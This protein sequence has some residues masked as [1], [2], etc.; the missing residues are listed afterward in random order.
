MLKKS[1]VIAATALFFATPALSQ[2]TGAERSMIE[3]IDGRQEYAL[4]VLE[5]TVNINSGSMNIKGVQDVGQ[6]FMDEFR[7]LGMDVEWIDGSAFNRAGHVIARSGSKGPH[8]LM[9]GHLDTVFEP[10]SPFQSFTRLSDTEASGPG[11]IDMKGG[12][13]IIIESLNALKEVGLLD[14]LTVTVVLIGD[15]ESSGRPFSLSRR[16]LMDAADAADIALG[17]E[18]GDGNPGTAVIARRGYTDWKLSV[19]AT[20]AHSSQVFRDDIGYGAVYETARILNAF[21]ETLSGEPNLTFNPGLILGGTSVDHDEANTRGDAFGKSNVIAEFTT[22]AGDLRTL[23][24]DQLAR[25]KAT[26]EEIVAQSLPGA[27][28]SISFSDGYPPL[29]PTDG[30]RQLLGMLDQVSRDLGTGAVEAVDPARAGAADISFT[31]GRV[32]RALDG[33]G[34]MGD[35]GHTVEETAD[36]RTLPSQTKRIA[37]LM[38]RLAASI[39]TD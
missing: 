1:L 33:L 20:P 34:L 32:D 37:I 23:S 17:F 19:T 9:I 36:L 6:V 35:Y 16:H 39:G 24:L 14:D 3:V 26:M 25:T 5:R 12:N 8:V 21:R 4:D 13:V 28:A 31:A 27:S 29:G 38:S 11:I 22:V 30:N 15:E 7:K 2:L 10:E 18:D